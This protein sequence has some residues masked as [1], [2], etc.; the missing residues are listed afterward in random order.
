LFT[1]RSFFLVTSLLVPVLLFAS[2][3]LADDAPF[4]PVTG[5]AFALTTGTLI[6]ASTTFSRIYFIRKLTASIATACIYFI[7]V[8]VVFWTW[9]E[10]TRFIESQEWSPIG[11][12]VLTGP[13]RGAAATTAVVAIMGLLWL[14]T[15]VEVP[16]PT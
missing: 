1:I 5:F 10:E 8:F 9:A 3:T 4:V 11:I 7:A 13:I 2:G 15:A 12:D 6:A 16:E 14:A